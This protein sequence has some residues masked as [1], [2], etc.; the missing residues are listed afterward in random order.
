M[1]RDWCVALAETLRPFG[2]RSRF[3]LRSEPEAEP[4]G[5][6][7]IAPTFGYLEIEGCGPYSARELDWV[8]AESAADPRPLAS[9]LIAAGLTAR[10][11]EHAVRVIVPA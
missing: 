11:E 1:E 7:L 3:K 8:E 2:S 5:R 6:W 9:A 10:I 4:W